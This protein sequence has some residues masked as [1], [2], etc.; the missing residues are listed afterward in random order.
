MTTEY[1]RDLLV[2]KYK[3]QPEKIKI[4][5]NP[6]DTEDRF[7]PE[8]FDRDE[9]RASLGIDSDTRAISF[10]ARLHHQKHPEVFIE[11]ANELVA[12]ERFTFI[13]VGSGDGADGLISQIKNAKNM[14]YLGDTTKPEH[15]M[16]AVD[17][18]V[19][20]S[21]FE[22]YPLITLIA[23][24]LHVPILVTDVTGHREQ[25]NDGNF[26]LLYE[27]SGDEKTDARILADILVERYDELI[28]LG[29]NGRQFVEQRHSLAS[30][31]P[32]YQNI[33]QEQ[34][35]IDDAGFTHRVA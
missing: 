11:L 2:A 9:I 8:L 14:V 27:S 31:Y 13:V 3:E 25:V 30:V 19:C 18:L 33:I 35:E 17:V 16:A 5:N 7:N 22:G 29:K 6:L 26:G 32:V 1:W 4:V 20:P 34:L 23:G 15:Y 21:R 10:M 12:D 24:A 28:S